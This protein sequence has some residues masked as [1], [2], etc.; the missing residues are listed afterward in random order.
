MYAPEMLSTY[1]PTV[2][3]PLQAAGVS[4]FIRPDIV[5][6]TNGASYLTQTAYGIPITEIPNTK[7]S[8]LHQRA[9]A[10]PDLIQVGENPYPAKLFTIAIF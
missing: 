8:A 10:N 1:D 7:T 5:T 2:I 9:T 6:T 4:S 3:G